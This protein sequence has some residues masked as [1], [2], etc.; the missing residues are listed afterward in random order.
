MSLLG[1]RPTASRICSRIRLF[2][3]SEGY[4]LPSEVSDC[5]NDI[6]TSPS[7]LSPFHSECLDRTNHQAIERRV[8]FH[9]RNRKDTACPS[10]ARK[11]SISLSNRRRGSAT[12][13]DPAP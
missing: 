7:L 13:E 3:G 11:V 5:G 9:R 12:G 2:F 4:I 6:R 8:A 1:R 10:S